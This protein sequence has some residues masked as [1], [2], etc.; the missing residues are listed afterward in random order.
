MYSIHLCKYVQIY[1]VCFSVQT[2]RH[3]NN[4]N[5]Q[6]LRQCLCF[7]FFYFSLFSLISFSSFIFPNMLYCLKVYGIGKPRIT[8]AFTLTERSLIYPFFSLSSCAT[9][10]HIN[11]WQ[12]I[13]IS[14]IICKDKCHSFVTSAHKL[15][16]VF[17]YKFLNI[18]LGH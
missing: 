13:A 8:F 9:P 2:Q 17:G 10:T 11:F 14:M 15:P 6:W 7:S 3:Q 1:L 18:N 16:R 12:G 5:Y 4:S